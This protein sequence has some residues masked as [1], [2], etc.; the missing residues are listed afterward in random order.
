MLDSALDFTAV[1]QQAF[2][3]SVSSKTGNAADLLE[4]AVQG[5]A[6]SEL[7]QAVCSL[8]VDVS[9]SAA[10]LLLERASAGRVS[11]SHTVPTSAELRVAYKCAPHS[12][13]EL[14]A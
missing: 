11:L 12:R 4:G 1:L 9:A 6:E 7:C 13:G 5:S 8:P 10:T 3:P 14:L 2:S